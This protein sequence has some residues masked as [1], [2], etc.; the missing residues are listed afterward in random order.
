MLNISAKQ[1]APDVTQLSNEEPVAQFSQQA[2]E[3][4]VEIDLSAARSSLCPSRPGTVP[5]ASGATGFRVSERPK[6]FGAPCQIRHWRGSS[7]AGPSH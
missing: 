5:E 3:L 2:K 1:S 6:N 7:T 4:G